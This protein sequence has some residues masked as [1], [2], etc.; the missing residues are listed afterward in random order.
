MARHQARFA[1]N[2]RMAMPL[3]TLERMDPARV[4]ALRA[5][6]ATFLADDGRRRRWSDTVRAHYRAAP[7]DHRGPSMSRIAYVNGRYVPQS[8]ASV[9]VEDRGYQFADGVYEVLYLAGWPVPGR[10]PSHGPARAFVA[11]TP[12]SPCPWA[13]TALLHVLREVVRRNR[14]R[15]GLVYMQVTRGVARRDHAFPDHSRSPPALVVTCRRTPAVPQERRDSGPAP[16]SPRRIS[17]GIAATSSLSACCPTC[18]P[19]R[20][21]GRPAAVEAIMIAKD[22]T[23]TEGSLPPP[24]GWWTRPAGYAPATS[25]TPSCPAARG[26]RC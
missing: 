9:N 18:S 4:T 6:A 19:S 20:R 11:R 8:E 21:P 3:R 15:N 5:R 17:A 1:G 25:A 26:S 16:P 14:L 12:A 10:G 23:V 7:P 13:R 2:N 22:G 24:S